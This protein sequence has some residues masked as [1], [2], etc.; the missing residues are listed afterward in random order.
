M[1]ELESIILEKDRTQEQNKKLMELL[2]FKQSYLVAMQTE[3]PGLY[4]GSGFMNS[5]IEKVRAEERGLRAE[6]DVFYKTYSHY[7]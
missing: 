7:R 2:E 6:G 4:Q 5:V 3:P 1:E